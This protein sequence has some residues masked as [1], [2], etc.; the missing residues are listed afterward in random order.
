M[1]LKE[2]ERVVLLKAIAGEG[3]EAGDVGTIVH[4]YQDGM[5]YEVE[6]VALDG[7][8]R[9]VATVEANQ[10]RPVTR[11]DMTHAREVQIA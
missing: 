6:F 3:L 9:A 4:V 5:A 1:M 7:H 2:L 8:T 11:R 10:V